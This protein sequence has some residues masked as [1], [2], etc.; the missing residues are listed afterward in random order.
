[1]RYQVPHRLAWVVQDGDGQ[2]QPRL[3]LMKLP[4]GEPLLLEG[5]AA[6][7]W[8]LAG[9][10]EDVPRALAELV[11]RPVAEIADDTDAFLRRPCRA[12]PVDR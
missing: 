9:D 7:I 12:G 5:S 4:N 6:L 3:V 8:L 2:A 11:G 10:T 1:M